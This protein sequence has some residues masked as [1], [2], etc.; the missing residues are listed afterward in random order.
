MCAWRGPP[1]PWSAWRL[2][3]WAPQRW[4][5][6]GWWPA[7]HCPRGRRS[8]RGLRQ[9][10]R[11]QRRRRRRSCRVWRWRVAWPR[12]S[13]CLCGGG[14]SRPSPGSTVGSDPLPA[15]GS[16]ESTRPEGARRGRWRREHAHPH[17]SRW[18]CRWFVLYSRSLPFNSMTAVT[19]SAPT[20]PRW[21][22]HT[23][24]AGQSPA[25]GIGN[26]GSACGR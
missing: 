17:T 19:W 12:R 23:T 18:R 11:R 25:E 13:R 9:R 15:T 8:L 6:G 10:A 16:R 3:S 2:P 21:S 20:A 1:P 4:W 24:W 14:A 5:R 22:V 7:R 26:A